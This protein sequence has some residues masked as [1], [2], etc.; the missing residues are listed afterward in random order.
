MVSSARY[1]VTKQLE[2]V[3]VMSKFTIPDDKVLMV[4]MF[5]KGG[6]AALIAH[7]YQ[8]GYFA[9][10]GSPHLVG[11]GGHAVAWLGRAFYY[12]PKNAYV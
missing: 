10:A 3:Y 2:R 6:G 1:L 9:S 7:D 5:E 11:N 4:E 12:L 8:P